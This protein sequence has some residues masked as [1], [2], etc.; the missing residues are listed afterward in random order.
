M[1]Y[2]GMNFRN[3]CT[4][5]STSP[6][7]PKCLLLYYVYTH[8]DGHHAVVIAVESC[9]CCWCGFGSCYSLGYGSCY[10]PCYGLLLN[11]T[12]RFSPHHRHRHEATITNAPGTSLLVLQVLQVLQVGESHKTQVWFDFAGGESCKNKNI[13]FAWYSSLIRFCRWSPVKIYV[14]AISSLNQ[15]WNFLQ[16]LRATSEKRSR[17]LLLLLASY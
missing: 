2:V 15:V 11:H 7:N 17:K 5:S 9:C 8:W 1:L 14:P 13:L 16:I 10:G 6:I 4:N 12:V 3:D